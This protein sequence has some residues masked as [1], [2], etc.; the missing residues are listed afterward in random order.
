MS[1]LAK[2][3]LIFITITINTS[4][5]SIFSQHTVDFKTRTPGNKIDD[6]IIDKVIQKNIKRSS[7]N[8][9]S[10]GVNVYN[11]IVLLTGEVSSLKSRQKAQK[12]AENIYKVRK[13]FNYLSIEKNN[14]F[15]TTMTDTLITAALKTNLLYNPVTRGKDI[16]VVTQ[17]GT[18][19]LLG[20]VK[21]SIAQAAVTEARSTRG[22]K[23]IVKLFEL[24]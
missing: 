13:V 12:I 14:T 1:Y 4:C 17:S 24:L 7:I 5:N 8:S 15:I 2:L 3:L 23:K 19:Y 21:N 18:V 10:I 20:L 9:K 6:D 22:V 16:K 11:S